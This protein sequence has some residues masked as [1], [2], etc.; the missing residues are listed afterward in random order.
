VECNNNLL[1]SINVTGC[2]KLV[3]LDCLNNSLTSLDVSTNT[4]LWTLLCS[5]NMMSALDISSMTMWEEDGEYPGY[6]VWCGLQ[7][8]DDSTAQ[9][10][11]LT[12]REEQ[13]PYWYETASE[14]FDHNNGTSP[15]MYVVVEGDPADV[16]DE[17]TDPAFKAYCER[18]NLVK[19]GVLSMAEALRVTMLHTPNEGIVS[20]EGI[21]CFPEITQL[22]CDP[23]Q[24]SSIDLSRNTKIEKMTWPQ[25]QLTSLNISGCTSL[26][27]LVVFGNRLTSLDASDMVEPADYILCGQQTSNGSTPQ[28]LTLSLRE[29]QKPRWYSYFANYSGGFNSNV[30]IE[31]DAPANI[32]DAITDPVFKTYCEKFDTNKDGILT[33]TEAQAEKN[34]ISIQGMNITSLAGIE[35]F[36]EI[37]VLNCPVNQLTTLDVSK[38]TKLTTLICY[39]NRLT[40]LNISGCTALSQLIAFDNRMSTLNASDMA[41]PAEYMLLCGRQTSDGTTAQTNTLTLRTEQLEHWEQIKTAGENTGVV[42]AN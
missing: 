15:N 2:T 35:Y 20:L 42:L 13:K 21:E 16:F 38:N 27:E 26:R 37:T 4:A 29:E 7:R 6:A 41:N 36:T 14:P 5:G 3:Y 30:M 17:I 24:I 12:M 22:T 32:F 28:T 31:G 10:L 8:I 23:N 19:D 40:S 34:A 9:L 33:S 39:S 25:N 18:Y 11:T 1:T